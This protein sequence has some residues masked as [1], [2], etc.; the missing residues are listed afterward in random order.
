MISVNRD[1]THLDAMNESKSLKSYIKAICPSRSQQTV[2]QIFYRIIPILW[3]IFGTIGSSVCVC[4]LTRKRMYRNSTYVYLTFLAIVDCIVLNIGLLRDYLL[5]DFDLV[6]S[7]SFPCKIS[8]FSFYANVHLASWLL[9]AVS[10]DRAILVAARFGIS[11]QWCRPKHAIILSICILVIVFLID[12]HLLIF[13][14]GFKE[15]SA[16][17]DEIVPVNPYSYPACVI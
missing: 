9:T 4:V 17:L 16:N 6:I 5:Y 13:T 3:T 15:D 1:G 12:G 7:R 10:I 11:K 14:A 8:V 2:V